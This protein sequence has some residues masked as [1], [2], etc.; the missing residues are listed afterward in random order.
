MEK[1]NASGFSHSAKEL[2][3]SINEKKMV[4][5]QVTAVTANFLVYILSPFYSKKLKVLLIVV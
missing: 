4:K 1:V 2:P 3:N 5:K